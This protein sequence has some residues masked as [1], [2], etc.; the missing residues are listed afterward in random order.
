MADVNSR[1]GL[2]GHPV[3]VVFDDDNGDPQR[4]IAIARR[5]VDRDGV[6]AFF[7]TYMVTTLPA[8]RSPD[9]KSRESP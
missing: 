8:G 5:M 1:G 6:L 4:A 7:A 2:A 9:R 3:K